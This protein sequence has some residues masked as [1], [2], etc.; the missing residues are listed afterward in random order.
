MT[1]ASAQEMLTA[2]NNAYLRALDGQSYSI[3]SGL[4]TRQFTRQQISALLTQVQYWQGQVDR[5]SGTRRRIKV[6]IQ[7]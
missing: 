5:L 6:G 3:G 7:A 1:L 2:A 4:T